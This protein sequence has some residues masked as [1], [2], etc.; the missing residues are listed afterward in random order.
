MK[1]F[2]CILSMLICANICFASPEELSK[3]A[4]AFY[5][6]GNNKKA[7]EMLLQ[8]N[9]KERTSQDWLLLGNILADN[10]EKSNAVFMYT[11]AIEK[12]KKCY[13]AYYNIAN[14]NIE[15]GQFNMAVENYKKAARIKNDNAYIH[16]NLGCAYLKLGNLSSA[17]SSF[18]KAIMYK[19][20]VPE[21]H[22][23]LAYVY[24]ELKKDKLAKTYLA[25]YNKLKQE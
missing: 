12:D 23:N 11:K 19:S 16:Y 1:R 18:N 7:M 3:Q 24:K 8:I 22:Y 15:K 21:F 10:G 2:F 13:K 4:V 17:R 5:N 14:Y 25:N 6:D 9:E 20:D